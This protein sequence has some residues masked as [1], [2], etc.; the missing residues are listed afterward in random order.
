MDSPPFAG[1]NGNVTT[2]AHQKLPGNT[3]KPVPLH[4][5][6][7]LGS[8]TRFPI[9][10]PAEEAVAKIGTALAPLEGSGQDR[11]RFMRYSYQAFALV[12]L[13]NTVLFIPHSHGA[14]PISMP[15]A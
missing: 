9:R 2:T 13:Q 14:I 6:G 5:P 12:K 7:S 15:G 4:D 10:S 1:I 3:N 8:H 11:G